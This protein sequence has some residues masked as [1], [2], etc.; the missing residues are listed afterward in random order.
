VPEEGDAACNAPAAGEPRGAG[1]HDHPVRRDQM[2]SIGPTAQSPYVGDLL[3][4]ASS[5]GPS[6][7]PSAPSNKTASWLNSLRAPR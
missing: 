7:P 4:A 5:I 6:G 2:Q 3:R 1:D